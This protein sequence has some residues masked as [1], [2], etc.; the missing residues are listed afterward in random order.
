MSS[1]GISSAREKVNE[2]ERS[3]GTK[4]PVQLVKNKKLHPLHG[5]RLKQKPPFLRLQRNPSRT[6]HLERPTESVLERE[7]E[8]ELERQLE[9]GWREEVRERRTW[10]SRREGTRDSSILAARERHATEVSWVG[11]PPD[12]CSSPCKLERET[13]REKR[14]EKCL[15]GELG[16]IG[17]GPCS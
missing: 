2:G 3:N 14:R 16:G 4:P 10:R 5:S 15:L 6:I 12:C 17:I 8:R 9:R 7:N 11:H 13:P 1:G